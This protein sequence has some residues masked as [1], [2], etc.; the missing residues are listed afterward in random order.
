ME[1]YTSRP[2]KKAHKGHFSD[3]D[4]K[5]RFLVSHFYSIYHRQT[6]LG[7]MTHIYMSYSYD[8]FSNDLDLGQGH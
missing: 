3:L 8:D 4:V 2:F 6:K 7:R 5:K 1:T